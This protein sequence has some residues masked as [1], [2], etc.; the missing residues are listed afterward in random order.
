MPIDLGRVK[1]LCFDVDGT[2]SDT[3]DHWESV[4]TRVLGPL[5]FLFKKG[6]PQP[7]A[8]WLLMV[9]ESPMNGIYHW[10]DRHSLDDNVARLLSRLTHGGHSNKRNFWLMRGAQEL[11]TGVQ[12]R[13]PLSVVSARD[14]DT[15][16]RFLEQFDLGKFFLAVVT[17]QTCEFTKPFPQPVMHAAAAMGLVPSDCV[18]IG[19]TTVDIL[20]GKRAGA[21]T[22]GLLCGFGTEDELRKAGADL[23]ARDLEE[24]YRA[25]LPDLVTP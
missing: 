16:N 24:L 9:T 2:L 19:D 25:I 12:E 11:L 6:N 1:G 20:A 8:R 4:I 13:Y 3:D 10:L 5:R 22:V 21:Q 18:M 7:F 15:T 14:A 23:I 17:S